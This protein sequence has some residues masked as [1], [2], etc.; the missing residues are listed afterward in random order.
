M[1]L[2]EKQRRGKKKISL[3][4]P[5]GTFLEGGV[6]LVSKIFAKNRS[7]AGNRRGR[8]TLNFQKVENNNVRSSHKIIRHVVLVRL[9]V[10]F[11]T[12]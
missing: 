4:G 9:E 7:F 5:F 2:T 10:S 3:F 11:S 8:S 1:K 12:L 6:L